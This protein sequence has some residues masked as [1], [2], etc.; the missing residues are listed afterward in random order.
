MNEFSLSITPKENELVFIANTDVLPAPQVGGFMLYLQNTAETRI[1][2]NKL[3]VSV[4][5]YGGVV[6]WFKNVTVDEMAD[7]ELHPPV[8]LNGDA[9]VASACYKWD[10]MNNGIAG[11]SDGVLVK[12][13]FAAE[14]YTEINIKS[15][16]GLFDNLALHFVPV[17][18]DTLFECGVLFSQEMIDGQ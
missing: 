10:G 9:D 7:A 2:I 18:G 4:G 11:I 3:M 8:D 15:T 14:G 1:V 17:V 5:E 16:L 12:P 13:L 6:Q